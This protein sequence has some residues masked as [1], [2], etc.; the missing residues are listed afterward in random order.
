V[1]LEDAAQQTEKACLYLLQHS[2]LGFDHAWD[3]A[4]ENW[5]NRLPMSSS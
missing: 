1:V 2:K 3:P 4:R 5:I